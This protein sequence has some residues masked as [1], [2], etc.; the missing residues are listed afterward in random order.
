VNKDNQK[1]VRNI[2][3]YEPVLTI[4]K[5]DFETLSGNEK[6]PKASSQVLRACYKLLALFCFEDPIAQTILEPYLKMFLKHMK[7]AA[8][9]NIHLVILEYF[10]NNKKILLNQKL[11]QKTINLMVTY[12][13]ENDDL[14][15][16]VSSLYSLRIFL[17]LRQKV[18]KQ[19]QTILINILGNPNFKN[20]I[21]PVGN[22]SKVGELMSI[23]EKFGEE[24][25]ND[26]SGDVRVPQELEYFSVMLQLMAL[27][28]EEKNA[29][30]E[31]RCQTLFP[32][33]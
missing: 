26:E 13:D 12:I 14:S 32:L 19:N 5:M 8:N 25:N 28:S 11:V 22:K 17:R 10:K 27:C 2:K 33:R 21:F 6:R 18:I 24:L 1:L 30:S 3:L 20:L 7:K 31:S 29:A 16:K 4:I 15:Q 9:S 23:V